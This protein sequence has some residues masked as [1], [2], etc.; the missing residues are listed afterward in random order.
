MNK[1]TLANIPPRTIRH[2]T[3]SVAAMESVER[4]GLKGLPAR[5][6]A[7]RIGENDRSPEALLR[8]GKSDIDPPFTL[9]DIE[10]AVTRIVQAISDE[11]V[12]AIETDHDVDGTT[13]HAVIYRALTEWFGVD[14]SRI[15]SFIGLRLQ[16][17][18]GISDS[19]AD[20][21]L[22]AHPRADLIITADNGSS[23]EPRLRRLADAGVDVVVTDHHLLPEEGVP[24]SAYACVSPARA[25]SQ[26][27][28]PSIAGV[29]VAW[30]VM[31]A[32]RVELIQ[33]GL[34]AKTTPNMAS[35]LDY[36]AVGTVAD[37]VSLGDSVN[38]RAVVNAGLALIN[39]SPR[40]CWPAIRVDIDKNEKPMTAQGLGFGIGPRVNAQGR[41]DD[42]LIAV[43][44]F[45]ADDYEKA[46]QGAE[47]LQ[48]ANEQRQQIEKRLRD[49]ALMIADLQ[50]GNGRQ[51]IVIAHTEGHPGVHGIVASRVVEAFARP[52]VC[53]SEKVN[54]ASLLTGSCRGVAGVHIRDA[55]QYFA[56]QHPEY[57]VGFGGHEGA[58]GVTIH[59]DGLM[60]F[61][62]AFE[63]AIADQLGTQEPT[64]ELV[65]DCEADR[66]EWLSLEVVDAIS[67]LEPFGRG[68]EAP[69]LA[70]TFIIQQA[71]RLG[72]IEKT[73]H[74]KLT[75]MC[76][77]RIVSGVWF[78]VGAEIPVRVGSAGYFVFELQANHWNGQRELQMLIRHAQPATM[79]EA[80]SNG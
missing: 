27:P 34:I 46:R 48:R 62:A 18:Y 17:G 1:E 6:L 4:L 65:V 41:L 59:R 78:N 44:F 19:L 9:P 72:K 42:A 30:L 52:T 80:I 29:M 26:Y 79:E 51:S 74:W 24:Q 10:R 56:D 63:Q 61:E 60:A 71:K 54:D 8:A 25:D 16:E 75:L 33:S 58:G 57:I 45:L 40:P 15:Q 68:F 14:P 53:F 69:L 5:L 22:A 2:K 55:L 76:G 73:N 7:N 23:D 36:V 70:G 43:D 38:N 21:I 11:S 77:D 12:I 3:P 32:V 66:P 13:A 31:C 67:E 28:D 20:R 35:L 50:A 39:R 47:T 64:R 49:E 37:C